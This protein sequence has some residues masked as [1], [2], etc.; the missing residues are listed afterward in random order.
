MTPTEDT[1]R[2]F[3]RILHIFCDIVAYNY[4]Q[5]DER[6]TR[7]TT[8]HSANPEKN[9]EFNAQFG[10][11]DGWNKLPDMPDPPLFNISLFSSGRFNTPGST[12][13]NIDIVNICALF[14]RG[15][16]RGNGMGSAALGFRVG[17]NKHGHWL[18]QRNG[19][20]EHYEGNDR[21]KLE[22]DIQHLEAAQYNPVGLNPAD[23]FTVEKL[24]LNSDGPETT[25]Q[26]KELL[27]WF[28]SLYTA[29][30]EV[31]DVLEGQH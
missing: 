14:E 25:P 11:E 9:T 6:E 2:G 15:D 29:N 10:V 22:Q 12:Y 17:I 20:L 24:G 8:I 31:L 3:R 21:G 23:F 16:G 13:L 4:A 30:R 1:Y 26:L 7:F 27:N 28:L 19:A 18:Y 5:A